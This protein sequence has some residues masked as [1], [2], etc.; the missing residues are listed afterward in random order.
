MSTGLP[1][2]PDTTWYTL[3]DPINVAVVSLFTFVVKSTLPP[4][5]DNF[6]LN[7][8]GNNFSLYLALSIDIAQKSSGESVFVPS[9]KVKLVLVSYKKII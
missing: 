2:E 6:K 9:P 7:V 1:F 3:L 8:F 5:P 4:D